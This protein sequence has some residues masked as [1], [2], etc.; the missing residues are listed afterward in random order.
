MVSEIE[1]LRLASELFSRIDSFEYNNSTFH[2]DVRDKQVDYEIYVILED[3][4]KQTK[5]TEK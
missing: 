3:F 5:E 4:L 1:L 2:Y